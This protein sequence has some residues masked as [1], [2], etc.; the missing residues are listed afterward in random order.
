MKRLELPTENLITRKQPESSPINAEVPNQLSPAVIKG[1]NIP[2][3]FPKSLEPQILPK[4]DQNVTRMI[5]I[6]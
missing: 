6:G 5:P 4:I 2:V 1:L 3:I